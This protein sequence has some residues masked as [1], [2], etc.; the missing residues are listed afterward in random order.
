MQ[1]RN[2]RVDGREV[3][4]FDRFDLPFGAETPHAPG[5]VATVGT[6]E[7]VED[8]QVLDLTRIPPIPSVFDNLHGSEEAALAASLDRPGLIFLQSFVSAITAPVIKDGREHID[9]VPSQVV[10]E[11]V[12]YRLKDEL[13]QRIVGIVYPSAQRDD[14]VGCVLFVTHEDINA[15]I[16]PTKPPFKLLEDLTTIDVRP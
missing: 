2:P 9:Y 16:L 12:R 6:F 3:E 8:I 13:C 14:G 4:F 11:Y 1:R 10:T 7:L 5:E 15:D